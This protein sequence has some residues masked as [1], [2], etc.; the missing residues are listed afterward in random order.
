MCHFFS[1]H[2]IRQF[3][4]NYADGPA[5]ITQCPIQEGN[6]YIYE[7][8]VDGQS[9]TFFYHAHIN[10]LRATVHGALIVRPKVKPA[11]GEVEAE[12]PI[13][14]GTKLFLNSFLFCFSF[15]LVLLY[16]AV[17]STFGGQR[18]VH[19]S[20][21]SCGSLQD[22]GDLFCRRMVWYESKCVRTWFPLHS[23]SCRE[24]Y[25][26]YPYYQWQPRTLL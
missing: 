15:S 24:H 7:F 22:D 19:I 25:Q 20:A 10:W 13:I 3:G 17:C 9:G 26:R 5:H 8:T 18:V 2:G 4:T 1:R 21:G 16:V 11:Y 23:K 14:L 12:I 6:S